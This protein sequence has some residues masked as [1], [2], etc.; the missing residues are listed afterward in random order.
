MVGETGRYTRQPSQEEVEGLKVLWKTRKAVDLDTKDPAR[1]PPS[2]SESEW[3]PTIVTAFS[4]NHLEVGLLFLRSVGRAA[5]GQSAYNIS[6]VV[7]TMNEF[8][9][10][11]KT[12][13]AC[14][15]EELQSLYKVRTE[16]RA[17]EFEAW[18][19]WMRINQK[20]GYNGGRGK[21]LSPFGQVLDASL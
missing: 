5:V 16:V 3:Q 13:F 17:F 6:I 20:R 19:S 10:S 8:P 15:V 1:E 18:P 21:V 2:L 7:W 11:A 14:V 12:A 4:S 9:P